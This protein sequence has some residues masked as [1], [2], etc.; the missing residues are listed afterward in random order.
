MPLSISIIINTI[1]I[2]LRKNYILLSLKITF[3]K[4]CTQ[5]LFIRSVFPVQKSPD[6]RYSFF[7]IGTGTRE[8]F[9][10]T[11]YREGQHYSIY[12]SCLLLTRHLVRYSKR[13]S[14][15]YFSTWHS[16]FYQ[17]ECTDRVAVFR[18]F[19]RD[20]SLKYGSFKAKQE[21]C[22]GVYDSRI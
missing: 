14:W 1:K 2:F 19:R 12:I 21:N 17:F 7:G 15:W 4:W 5:N 18:F 10:T 13:T 3:L 8:I 11:R 22:I 20:L 6:F 16:C 9:W